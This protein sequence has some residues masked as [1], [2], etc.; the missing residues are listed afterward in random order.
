MCQGLVG[1]SG[2]W[3]ALWEGAGVGVLRVLTVHPD[4]PQAASDGSPGASSRKSRC[5]PLPDMGFGPVWQSPTLSL[6]RTTVGRGQR[7]PELEGLSRTETPPTH[8]FMGTPTVM[9]TCTKLSVGA[10]QLFTEPFWHRCTL[11]GNFCT[12][13]DTLAHAHLYTQ[14]YVSPW[15]PCPHVPCRTC[16]RAYTGLYIS[17]H[18]HTHHSVAHHSPRP[19]ERMWTGHCAPGAV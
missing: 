15:T 1:C 2:L 16:L 8:R 5:S 13:T 9:C 18:V 17:Q 19:G 3:S 6:R 10:W 14:S 7:R 4:S 11:R 12:H